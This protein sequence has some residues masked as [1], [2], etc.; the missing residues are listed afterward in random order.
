MKSLKVNKSYFPNRLELS[1]YESPSH[2]D[3][4]FKIEILDSENRGNCFIL[5]NEQFQKVK[6]WIKEIE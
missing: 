1:G 3:S 5:T 4:K 6:E 2:V